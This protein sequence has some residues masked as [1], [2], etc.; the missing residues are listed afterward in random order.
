MFRRCSIQK[1][2]ALQQP[3]TRTI[4]EFIKRLYRVMVRRY[5]RSSS[6]N[7]GQSSG[8]MK[9]EEGLLQHQDLARALS[10]IKNWANR[11]LIRSNKNE[12]GATKIAHFIQRGVL[13]STTHAMYDF[14]DFKIIAI[15]KCASIKPDSQLG[16]TEADF[17]EKD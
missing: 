16:S 10:K 8:L 3:S 17:Q 1:L 15:N 2:A 5:S 12:L 6:F 4:Q 11:Q 13:R 7:E 14:S 9:N